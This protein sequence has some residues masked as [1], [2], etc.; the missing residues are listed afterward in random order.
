LNSVSFALFFVFNVEILLQKCKYAAPGYDCLQQL[1]GVV[2]VSVCAFIVS[3]IIFK[4]IDVS[5]GL[6]L[7]DENEVAGLDSIEH[8]ETAYNKLIKNL[9]WR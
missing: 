1:K 9:P 7:S 4:V 8:S 6:R 5:I 3:W 2:I